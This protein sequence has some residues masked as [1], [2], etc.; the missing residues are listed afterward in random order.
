MTNCYFDYIGGQ[1]TTVPTHHF[2]GTVSIVCSETADTTKHPITIN[3]PSVTPLCVVHIP[4]QTPG[5]PTVDFENQTPTGNGVNVEWTVKGITSVVTG[6]CG[7]FCP[8][9]ANIDDKTGTYKGTMES[10]GLG[11]GI[12]QSPASRGGGSRMKVRHRYRRHYAH[13]VQ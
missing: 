8:L 4:G 9:T 12:F 13:Q 7:F 6:T 5:N 11:L 1:T 2:K 3:A 10:K